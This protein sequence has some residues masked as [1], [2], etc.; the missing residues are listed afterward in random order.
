M[1]KCKETPHP[2]KDINPDIFL[3]SIVEVFSYE[4]SEYEN[5][6]VEKLLIDFISTMKTMCCDVNFN[7]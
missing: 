2:L 5:I 3:D 6:N 1:S 4:S 7:I